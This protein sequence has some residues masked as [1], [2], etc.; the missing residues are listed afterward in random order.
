MKIKFCQEKNI[1]FMEYFSNKRRKYKNHL[2]RDF[3][4]RFFRRGDWELEIQN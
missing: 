3:K 2:T 4:D 1:I